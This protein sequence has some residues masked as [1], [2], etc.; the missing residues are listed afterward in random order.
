MGSKSW[1]RKS[2]RPKTST[3]G[4]TSRIKPRHAGAVP[5]ASPA[6]PQY[7]DDNFDRVLAADGERAH[8]ACLDLGA[9]AGNARVVGCQLRRIKFAV[10]PAFKS[11]GAD[12]LDA[13]GDLRVEEEHHGPRSPCQHLTHCTPSTC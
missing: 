13:G 12:A 11:A 1:V 10:I 2:T 8:A 3:R 4:S 6:M 9:K 5:F 7:L